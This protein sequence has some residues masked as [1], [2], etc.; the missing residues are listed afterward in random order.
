[1][2]FMSRRRAQPIHWVAANRVYLTDQQDPAHGLSTVRNRI[3]SGLWS[4]K[5]VS[6]AQ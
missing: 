4:R 1:M 5:D 3:N 6:Y 2:V